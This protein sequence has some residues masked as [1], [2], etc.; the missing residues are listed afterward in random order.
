[1]LLSVGEQQE[2]L[3]LVFT[4]VSRTISTFT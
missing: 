4:S 3:V 1:M 2:S